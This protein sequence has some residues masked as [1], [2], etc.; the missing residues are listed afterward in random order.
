MASNGAIPPPIP[1]VPADLK[2]DG[3]VKV[4]AAS[5]HWNWFCPVLQKANLSRIAFSRSCQKFGILP[6]K[7]L[8]NP[9]AKSTLRNPPPANDPEPS[10]P[11]PPVPGPT[12]PPKPII[13]KLP[14]NYIPL[15][16]R[17]VGVPPK[18]DVHNFQYRAPIETE[19]AAEQVVQAGLLTITPEYRRKVKESVTSHRIGIDGNL[20]EDIESTYLLESAKSLLFSPKDPP[21]PVAVFFQEFGDAREGDDFYIA[22]ESLSIQEL[23]ELQDGEDAL[24]TIEQVK[25]KLLSTN[26]EYG[27]VEGRVEAFPTIERVEESVAPMMMEFDELNIDEALAI[28]ELAKETLIP[29]WGN[30]AGN[31]SV[32]GISFRV[33]SENISPVYESIIECPA[34]PVL[35]DKPVRRDLAGV[36][37]GSILFHLPNIHKSC[38]L[39]TNENLFSVPIYAAVK[40]NYGL[41][42]Q[43]SAPGLRMLSKNFQVAQQFPFNLH[44]HLPF[45]IPVPLLFIP[46]S[47]LPTGQC[48]KARDKPSL[49]AWHKTE[50]DQIKCLSISIPPSLM[51]RVFSSNCT[52]WLVMV[53]RDGK[54]QKIVRKLQP[55]D[56]VMSRDLSKSPVSKEVAEGY[57]RCSFLVTL[58]IREGY[59]EQS[60]AFTS[61]NLTT[62]LTPRCPSS[63]CE[64]PFFSGMSRLPFPG[65]NN[66]FNNSS[67]ALQAL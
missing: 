51:D 34:V 32:A 39:F 7:L 63:P 67:V 5:A 56:T 31:I 20:L 58:D 16:E 2:F 1:E 21:D 62:F 65:L 52:Q 4:R 13:G 42:H 61:C 27:E 11:I 37:Q 15:Q 38:P 41:A 57:P 50:K 64:V 48:T 25:K 14:P 30:L 33:R 19:A 35:P 6:D 9:P 22:R 59:E 8:S 49:I 36:L 23:D 10:Q 43:H 12:R 24:L 18:D 53:R 55:R 26:L 3:G 46:S 28:V 60:L 45:P 54:S 47:F 17:T 44:E 66:I 40:N 29:N